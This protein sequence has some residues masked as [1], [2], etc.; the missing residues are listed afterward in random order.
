MMYPE[1]KTILYATD[2]GDHMGPVFRFAL[3][4]AKKHEAQIVALHVVEPLSSGVRLTIDIYMPEV[5]AKEVL[6]D[7]MKKAI[8]NMQQRLDEFCEDE[9]VQSPED[10]E[11]ITEVKVVSGRP[12]ETIT[13]QAEQLEADLIV[14]GTHTDPSF[15]AHLLGSTARKVTQLSKIPVLVVPVHE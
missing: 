1:I 3:G 5:S 2:M 4:I 9:L 13:Q 11:L 15:G 10:R 8:V 6:R 12:A 14:V 7:G